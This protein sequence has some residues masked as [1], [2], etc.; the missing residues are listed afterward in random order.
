MKL[1]N[2]TKRRE[3]GLRGHLQK[4]KRKRQLWSTEHGA[5][6][7]LAQGVQVNP[8]HGLVGY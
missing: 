7:P 4:N 3:L 6:T 8:L 5:Q 1:A 2:S